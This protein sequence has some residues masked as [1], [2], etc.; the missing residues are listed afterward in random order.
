MKI[1]QVAEFIMW[2]CVTWVILVVALILLMV[3]GGCLMEWFPP[4]MD[5]IQRELVR[6]HSGGRP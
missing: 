5:S 1:L 4:S 2:N 6:E 3:I